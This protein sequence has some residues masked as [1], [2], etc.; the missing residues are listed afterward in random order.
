MLLHCSVIYVYCVVCASP[1]TQWHQLCL[2][3]TDHWVSLCTFTFL[4]LI[5]KESCTCWLIRGRW[6]VFFF[7]CATK[8]IINGGKKPRSTKVYDMILKCVTLGKRGQLLE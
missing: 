2:F 8:K 4:N 3:I 7:L 5:L 1:E 6:T